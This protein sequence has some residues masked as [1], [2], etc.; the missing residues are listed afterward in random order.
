MK[1]LNSALVGIRRSPYQSILSIIIITIT[2]FIAYALSFITLGSN[3]VL[4]FF[5]TQ[6]QVIAFF[7][8]DA[9]ETEINNVANNI[10]TKSYVTEVKIVDKAQALEIYQESIKND[11]LMLELITE[12]ILPVSIEVAADNAKNLKQIKEDL[13]SQTSIEEA[14]LQENVIDKVI[15]WTNSMRIIGL[16][17]LIIL[18]ITSFLMIVVTIS[19]KISSKRKNIKIMKF[20]GAD[21]KYIAKPFVLE[22]II[23]SLFANFIAFALYMALILYT[24]PMLKELLT[25]IIEFPINWQIYLYQFLAAML[26][27]TILGTLASFTAVKRMLKK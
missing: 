5:E 21:R 22:A 10:G 4:S 17:A 14:V 27:A 3:Q 9:T 6:P 8:Q 16:F 18:T 1:A 2:F 12:D 11:P 26:L 25:G 19:M 13:E 20:I 24:T 15:R 7:N 23:N